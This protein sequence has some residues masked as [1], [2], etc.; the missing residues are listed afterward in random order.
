[1]KL[2]NRYVRIFLMHQNKIKVASPVV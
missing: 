2:S 1:V